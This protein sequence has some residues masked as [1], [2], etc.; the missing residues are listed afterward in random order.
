MH[1]MMEVEPHSGSAAL[2][3]V[4][5]GPVSPSVSIGGAFNLDNTASS[6]AGVV[7]YSDQGE[8][9]LGRLLVVHQSN[10]ANPQAAVRIQQAGAAHAVSIF[11]NPAAGAGDSSAEALDV[12][13]TNVLDS[14][15]GIR[16]QEAGRGTVK[17]THVKPASPDANAA[18]LSIGL[19]GA[20]TQCQG[21]FIGNDAGN[22]TSGPLIHIR[23]GGPGSERLVL[24][25]DGRLELP[26]P[27]RAGGLL[28]GSDANL[29][30]SAQGALA[31]DGVIQAR[32]TQGESLLLDAGADD[33]PAPVADRQIRLYLK[34]NKLVIQ[35]N[36]GGSVL[37]TTIPL[38]SVAPYPAVQAVTTD[39]RAP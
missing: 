15:V 39:T 11:H 36:K 9:A 5:S 25:G 34:D 22:A 31:T 23:N 4:P 13:S 28:I 16:G 32:V 7:L 21:I 14:A 27:D 24:T 17:I 19:L 20:G 37:Y 30:R 26:V 33:P 6:G 1:H 35:W 29:Y 3:L 38:D 10:A 12:V 2:K 18:A 8:G